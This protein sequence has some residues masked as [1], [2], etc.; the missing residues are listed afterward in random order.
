M[1]E[2]NYT[3]TWSNIG[4]INLG[5][6]NLGQLTSVVSYRMMQYSLRSVL[7]KRVGATEAAK[8][9]YEAG[10]IAGHEFCKNMLVK[11]TGLYEFVAQLQGVLR[12]LRIGLLRFEEIDVENSTFTLAVAE[13]IDCSGLPITNETVCDFDEGFIAGILTE[14]LGKEITAKET[15]CWSNGAKVCRFSIFPQQ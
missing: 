7:N 9:Y 11:E 8:I 15:D 14:Y 1:K 2:N 12:D 5:R 10:K 3:F 13:D 6:P 4:D